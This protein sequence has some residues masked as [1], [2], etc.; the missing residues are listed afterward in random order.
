MEVRNLLKH[1]KFGFG[2]ADEDGWQRGNSDQF[3]DLVL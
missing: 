2:D 3:D 1:L